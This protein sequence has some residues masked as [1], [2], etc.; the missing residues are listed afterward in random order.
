[1]VKS[2]HHAMVRLCASGGN[3]VLA[4]AAELLRDLELATTS[5]SS[6]GMAMVLLATIN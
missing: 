4:V 2:T 6:G 5:A 1:M 3:C